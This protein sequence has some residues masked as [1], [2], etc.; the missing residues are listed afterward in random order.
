MIKS[1]KIV[2]L[3]DD[4][5]QKRDAEKLRG[6]FANLYREEDL[7]HNHKEDGKSIYRMPLIQYKVID[8]NLTIIAYEKGV[9][10]IADKFL[11]VNELTINNKKYSNF[12]TQFSVDNKEF[13]ISDTLQKYGFESIWLP[14]NQ[15]NYLSFVNNKLNLNTVLQNHL[16]SNFKGVGITVDK[17]IMVSG[18][19]KQKSVFIDNIEHFGFTGNFVT[20]VVMPE[21]MGIGQK[22]S[23]GFGVVRKI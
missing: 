19:F 11:K 18:E 3:C 15:K 13:T 8:G 1:G 16:L 6:Y 14:V 17:R 22:K 7:F 23:I 10:V 5:F 2:Y 21:L 4:K 20:N 9:E 12:E